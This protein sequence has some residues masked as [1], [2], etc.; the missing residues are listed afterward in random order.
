M[1]D[2]QI[3]KLLERGQQTAFVMGQVSG[4]LS[5]LRNDLK[6]TE[7]TRDQLIVETELLLEFLSAHVSQIYYK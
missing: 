5:S 4:L 6:F 7:K 1:N 3:E 2:Q